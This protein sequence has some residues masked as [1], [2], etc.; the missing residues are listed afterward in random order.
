MDTNGRRSWWAL[1]A[2]SRN[3]WTWTRCEPRWKTWSALLSWRW[4]TETGGGS[5]NLACDP[6]PIS[7]P[8]KILRPVVSVGG[9]GAIA[10]AHADR[11]EAAIHDVDAVTRSPGFRV[12]KVSY[13]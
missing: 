3:P 7:T 11:P 6:Y 9:T 10:V 2:I 8:A 4:S 5:S 12:H 1:P 13:L